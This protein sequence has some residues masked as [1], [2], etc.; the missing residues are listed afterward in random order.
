MSIFKALED[1]H[2]VQRRLSDLLCE[3]HGDSRGRQELFERLTREMQTH[4]ASEERFFYRP[5][6]DF[7][8]TQP[9][10]RHSMAEHHEL[11]ELVDE[12]ENTDYSSPGWLVHAKQLRERL[13]HHLKEEEEE[14]FPPARE[15]LTQERS[16]LLGKRYLREIEAR[17]DGEVETGS[18]AHV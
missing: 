15:V 17:K 1:S 11:D 5:L 8:S 12:L 10:A 4:A 2:R 14:I 3:T 18:S 13:H 16:E 9:L 7:D 6:M